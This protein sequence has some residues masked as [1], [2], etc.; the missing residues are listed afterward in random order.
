[1]KRN[2]IFRQLKDSECAAA[3]DLQFE[4]VSWLRRKKNLVTT[5]IDDDLY[6]EWQQKGYNYGLFVDSEL[7]VGLSLVPEAAGVWAESELP[8]SKKLWLHSLA[9]AI[10]HKGKGLGQ[11]AVRYAI[12][13]AKSYEAELYLCCFRGNGFLPAFYQHLGFAILDSQVQEVGLLG[14]H[15]IVLMRWDIR[16]VKIYFDTP[17]ANDQ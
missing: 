2:L 3:Y 13:H 5:L 10:V 17:G 6:Y 4:A 7:A 12:D 11:L 15:E 9:T 16:S 1:M 8:K 14:E